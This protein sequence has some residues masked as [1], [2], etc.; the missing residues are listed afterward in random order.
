MPGQ[1]KNILTVNGGSSSIKFALYSID[2]APVPEFY[3]K[4]DRIGLAGSVLTAIDTQTNSKDRYPANAQ[5]IREAA[6]FLVTWLEQQKYFDS[7]AAIGHRVVHGMDHTG[8]ELITQPLVNELQSISSY[9]PDHLP[10]EIELI[11]VFRQRHPQLPQV[12]CFDTSFHTTIP[13][14]AQQLPIPRRFDNAGV[15]RYGFHGL[16]YSYIMEEL[17]RIGEPAVNG[18]IIVAHLG[19][20][21]SMAAIK[22]SKSVDTSMGFTPA[23]GL[24]MGTRP[25]DLDPGVAWYMIQ[26]EAMTP[27]QFN[28]VINHQSGLLGVSETSSDMEDLLKIE[29]TDIRAEEAVDLFCYQAKKWIGSFT[30][31]LGGLDVLVFTGGIGENSP[32]VRKR[33]VDGL[34]FMGLEINDERNKKNETIISIEG[35]RV[36]V[37][38]I[39]TN[40]ELM[41]AK[42]T[43]SVLN[44]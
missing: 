32:A 37:Y 30:A 11:E 21:A 29:H 27:Q 44:L 14:V 24:V 25:G 3:G 15:K 35:S 22:D 2:D 26:K 1:K 40:E 28:D 33:I 43:R 23:G 31:V 4:I 12:A 8:A 17:A 38:A 41:I 9:D 36:M 16:S 42:T 18:R 19:S 13:R 34:Q 10:G 39:P 5:D 7:I 6:D 20:G